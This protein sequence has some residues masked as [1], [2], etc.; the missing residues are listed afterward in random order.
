MV[1]TSP[2]PNN[3][4]LYM[5]NPWGGKYF[6]NVPLTSPTPLKSGPLLLFHRI[7]SL[8]RFFLPSTMSVCVFACLFVNAIAEIRLSEVKQKFWSK[9]F[10]LIWASDDT[11]FL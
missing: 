1:N 6:Q 10:A 3:R 9:V 4:P 11:F 7:S 5:V 2:W 8:G